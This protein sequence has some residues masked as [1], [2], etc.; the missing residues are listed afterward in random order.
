MPYIYV[1]WDAYNTRD[2]A[3]IRWGVVIA[4]GEDDARQQAMPSADDKA[5]NEYSDIKIVVRPL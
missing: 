4:D 3:C 5:F 1:V 2:P